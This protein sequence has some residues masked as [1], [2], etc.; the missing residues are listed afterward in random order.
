MVGP[1]QS[2]DGLRGILGRGIDGVLGSQ[3]S[4]Q[5]EFGVDQVDGGHRRASDPRIL[6]GQVAETADPKI[7][8]E[9]R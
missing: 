1:T 7:G 5:G 6:H 8:D 2:L 9:V 3:L 4:G